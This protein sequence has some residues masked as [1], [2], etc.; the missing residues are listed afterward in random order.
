MKL[1]K[2]DPVFYDSFDL[3]E[4]GDIIFDECDGPCSGGAT[5][6]NGSV[7]TEVKK[8]VIKTKDHSFYRKTGWAASPP[9]AY[10]I[11]YWQKKKV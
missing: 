8:K 4:V 5:Y 3:I 2:R 7:V 6:D 10:Y 1:R 9:T 11:A